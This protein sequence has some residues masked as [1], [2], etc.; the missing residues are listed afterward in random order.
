MPAHI[1]RGDKLQ[2]AALS[3]AHRGQKSDSGVA[4]RDDAISERTSRGRRAEAALD[5]FDCQSG[6]RHETDCGE[7]GP[8]GLRAVSRGERKSSRPA[9]HRFGPQRA[10][11]PSLQRLCIGGKRQH[12]PAADEPRTERI[13]H[14]LERAC[15]ANSRDH[16][17]LQFVAQARRECAER[18]TADMQ[19]EHTQAAVGLR[20]RSPGQIGTFGHRRSA[21]PHVQQRQCHCGGK[22]RRGGSERES[23]GMTHRLRLSVLPAAGMMPAYATVMPARRPIVLSGPVRVASQR[24][25]MKK[26]DDAGALAL[27]RNAEFR[28][29]WWARSLAVVANQM[30]LVALGWQMYTL[31]GS[32]WDLGLVGLVQFA[33]SVLLALP[34]GHALDRFER[35]LVLI[36]AVGLQAAAALALAAASQGEWLGR[37]GILA[38]SALLGAARTFQMPA[39]Q[40]L[41]PQLVPRDALQRAVALGST[42]MQAAI[43]AGPALGGLTYALGPAAVYALAA[44]L[45]F[46]GLAGLARL[47]ARPMDTASEPPSMA[48]VLAGLQFIGGHPVMLGAITLD[49]FAVLLGG[50][51]AL[52][53]IFARDILGSG[54]WGLGLLR[55]AP[56]AGALAMSLALVRWPIRRHS[57][58]ILLGAVAVFGLATIV[59]G[60][61]THFGASLLALA[62]SGAADMLS[63]A[64]RMTLVQLETP[65]AMR[66]RV[67]AVNTVFI[68]ASNQLG[69][70]ES[71][72]TAQW[73]GPVGSVVIGGVGTLLVVAAWIRLFPA[74]ARRD[75]LVPEP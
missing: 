60:V 45:Q 42:T 43:V 25:A 23:Q 22:Y 26:P 74:L 12:Q 20:G 73:F 50:A 14:R 28:R 32:A 36:A 47:R 57:G 30:L 11:A 71:G 44:A 68:G 46:A 61:S 51:V 16:G 70:F 75:L 66:G 24:K 67:S 1:A 27:L 58:P 52:L 7:R 65:D 10:L 34:A 39:S 6:R 8:I 40:A 2:H 35:R 56:S 55:A 37:T 48:T 29:F 59:F 64:I 72:V 49:L 9:F 62:V 38:A 54:P 21:R 18:L 31:T 4:E 41:L 5:V 69:E 15:F 33:P 17:N 13:D 3:A 53:P 63:I 19:A